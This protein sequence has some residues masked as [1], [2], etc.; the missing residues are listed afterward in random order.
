MNTK[1]TTVMIVDDHAIL[2]SGLKSLLGAQ[3]DIGVAA[4][5]SS[6]A[7][8]VQ[9][10]LKLRPDVIL[11]DLMMPDLDGTETMRRI[12]AKW[13]A[14][15]VLVLT[16]FG[17]SNE[18]ARAFEAGAAGAVLKTADFPDILDAI[19]S[20][21]AG[22]KWVATEIETLLE[23]DPPSPRLTKR[24]L[25]ILASITRGLTNADIAVELGISAPMVNEHLNAIFTK[26]GAANRTEAVGIALRKHLLRF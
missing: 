7:A 22:R 12:R 18:I 19:R 2:R 9:M 20:V 21:A 25:E 16:S 26:L 6:G 17:L 24:Q 5:T 8:A 14:A 13:P 23:N 11:M 3:P 15:K 1:K 4:D 10:A